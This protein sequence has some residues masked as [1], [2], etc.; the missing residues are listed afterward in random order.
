VID[1]RDDAKIPHPRRA[2][3]LTRPW[4][5]LNGHGG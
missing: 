1:V 2:N 5:R 4:S 3:E